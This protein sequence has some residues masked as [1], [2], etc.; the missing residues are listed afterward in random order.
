M[1]DLPLVL[2]LETP[3]DAEAIQH[4]NER[5]FGPGRFARTAYRIRERADPDPSLSF[6]ARVGTLMVGANAM[7]PI[8]IGAAKALLLGPLIVEPVFRSQGI[9]EALVARSLEAAKARGWK[10][11]IL[12]GDE[13]Y[14]ARVGFQRVP[15]GRIV[16]PGP[17]DPARL[18]YCEL[19]GGALEAAQGEA[20]PA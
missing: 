4:L 19:E 5:V 16:L 20:R 14:Y 1:A 10:L 18:L 12:V 8:V 2:E 17:V 7:T 9:G 15:S 3:D 11:V 13:P 6:V